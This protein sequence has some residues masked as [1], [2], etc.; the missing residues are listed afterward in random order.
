M[1]EPIDRTSY[2]T[3]CGW[4]KDTPVMVA[5]PQST[6]MCARCLDQYLAELDAKDAA[7]RMEQR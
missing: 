4:C 2:V 7:E 3:V 5:H 1:M 6:G